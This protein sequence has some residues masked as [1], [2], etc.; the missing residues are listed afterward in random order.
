MYSNQWGFDS[1][2][3]RKSRQGFLTIVITSPN[4]FEK[5]YPSIWA[6]AHSRNRN[7]KNLQGWQK[8]QLLSFYPTELKLSQE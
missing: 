5:I 8:Q 3:P 6:A 4:I 2:H 1:S 7:Q